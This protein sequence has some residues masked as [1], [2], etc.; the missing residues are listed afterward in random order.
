MRLRQTSDFPIEPIKNHRFTDRQVDAAIVTVRMQFL[1]G[2]RVSARLS[3]PGGMKHLLMARITVEDCVGLVPN[4][5]ELVLLAAERARQIGLGIGPSPHLG[6]DKKTVAALREI[7][8]GASTAEGLKEA[9]IRRMMRTGQSDEDA[10]AEIGDVGPGSHNSEEALL[11]L[12]A[13]HARRE[14]LNR[15]SEARRGGADQ[16]YN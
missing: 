10:P 11:S 13:A 2:L 6:K 16:A 12:H 8:A 9:C 4:R 14:K 7:A 5:F 1:V 15:R 3:L